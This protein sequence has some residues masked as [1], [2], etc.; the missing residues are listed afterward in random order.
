M[1]LFNMIF[2]LLVL[3]AIGEVTKIFGENIY[4]AILEFLA[5]FSPKKDEIMGPIQNMIKISR[6]DKNRMIRMYLM[7]LSDVWFYNTEDTYMYT[8]QI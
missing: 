2:F 3:G 8:T 7:Y 6:T 1:A 5:D 4:T